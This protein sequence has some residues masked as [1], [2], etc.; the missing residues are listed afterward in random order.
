MKFTD[1]ENTDSS[2]TD[3]LNEIQE[4]QDD[5]N[6]DVQYVLTGLIASKKLSDQEYR[7]FVARVLHKNKFDDIAF[8]MGLSQSSVKTYYTRSLKKLNATALEIDLKIKRK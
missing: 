2:Y 1:I 6:R 5:I 8:E 4:Y 7:V 3:L